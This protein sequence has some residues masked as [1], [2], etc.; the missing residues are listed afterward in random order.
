[1]S[2]NRGSAFKH[3]FER[4]R[5]RRLR[6]VSVNRSSEDQFNYVVEMLLY[7]TMGYYDEKRKRGKHGARRVVDDPQREGSTRDY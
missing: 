6:D 3:C 7:A 1:M 4:Y 5:Y 2:G